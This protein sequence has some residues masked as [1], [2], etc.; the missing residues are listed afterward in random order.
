MYNGTMIHAG[1]VISLTDEDASTYRNYLDCSAHG[2]GKDPKPED[3][4]P[5]E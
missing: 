2:S 5:G 1:S 4:T 3:A